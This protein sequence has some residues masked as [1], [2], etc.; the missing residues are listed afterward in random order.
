MTDL[1]P[2]R[3]GLPAPEPPSP[4]AP[5]L[6]PT[7]QNPQGVPPSIDDPRPPGS[8]GAGARAAARRRRSSPPR[9]RAGAA[10]RGSGA[11]VGSDRRRRRGLVWVSDDK[12]GIRRSGVGDGFRYRG[13]DGRLS[14]R[15]PSCGASAPS[16][17]RR[18]TRTSG[19]ARA[20]TAT[21]RPP[22]ATRA[23]ASS[24]ATT[25]DWRAGARRR[26]VRAHARVRRGAAA[27]PRSAS[28]PTSPRR[29][30][31][32]ARET[33]LA[34]IVR[35]LDTTC[36]RVGN[37]E[38]ARNNGSFGLTTLRNR[39]AAVAGAAA[40]LQLSR[41]E[42]HASTRSTLDDPR[43][44][45]VVRRCQATAGPGAV[46][47]RRRRRRGARRRLGRRQRLPPRGGRRRLHRQGLP[48]L[49]R[50]RA[51]A[52]R[53]G[54]SRAPP[55]A[56]AGRARRSCSA[57]SRGASATRSRS[58]GSRTSIPRVLEALAQPGRQPTLLERARQGHA[59]RRPRR[60]RAPPAGVPRS[61]LRS[62]WRLAS[63]RPGAAYTFPTGRSMMFLP[64][65]A[66][67]RGDPPVEEPLVLRQRRRPAS[68]R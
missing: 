50:H 33:V 67:A 16:R 29:S 32:A 63:R 1:L 57:R 26:Q 54:P 37:D 5:H 52:R 38:Y 60:R 49:A 61:R 27:H 55:R 56:S 10:A 40:A 2:L 44:A 45:R 66:P 48:H 19:S 4:P 64:H 12:P 47:V 62:C 6:P 42:R 59:P 21:C 23:A 58:A 9:E 7:P 46:P 11:A 22:A 3:A 31:D 17:S 43:V 14:A 41:Q 51:R 20:R 18:P 13:V 36:V 65:R 28:T 30:A 25:R 68:A 35:L 34:T 8:P 15:P 24:T 39:H 53:C